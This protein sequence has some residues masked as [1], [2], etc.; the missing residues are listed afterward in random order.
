MLVCR[1][2]FLK[3]SNLNFH[4]N[5]STENRVV[6]CGRAERGTEM[7]RI[8]FAFRIIANAP[9]KTTIVHLAVLLND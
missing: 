6:L 8:I 7:M 9:K 2:I 1:E 3:Y 5:S 4:K